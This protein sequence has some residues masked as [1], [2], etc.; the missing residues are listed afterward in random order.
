M[1]MCFTRFYRGSESSR[2]QAL[3]IFQTCRGCVD[4]LDQ[5]LQTVR[6]EIRSELGEVQLLVS[7]TDGS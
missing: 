5:P 6:N 1:E 3:E 7:Q 2:Q 4:Y